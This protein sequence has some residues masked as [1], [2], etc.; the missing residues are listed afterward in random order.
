MRHPRLH[1]ARAEDGVEPTLQRDRPLQKVGE[2]EQGDTIRAQATERQQ[3]SD[4]GAGF[5]C[6]SGNLTPFRVDETEQNM[7][8]LW[9]DIGSIERGIVRAASIEVE[10]F[11]H[12]HRAR[13]RYKWRELNFETNRLQPDAI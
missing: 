7:R 9:P 1:L 12:D 13:L 5:A 6:T 4:S 8:R 3:V 2:W 11:E 10:A